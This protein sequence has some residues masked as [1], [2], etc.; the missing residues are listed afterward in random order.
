[1]LKWTYGNNS[2]KLVYDLVV[3]HVL[4]YDLDLG[5]TCD[6]QLWT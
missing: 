4:I 3:Q 5:Y 1:M 2:V 6:Y